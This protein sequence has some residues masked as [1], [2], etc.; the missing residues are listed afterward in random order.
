MRRPLF[1]IW[2]RRHYIPWNKV[3]K[4]VTGMNIVC[5]ALA[6]DAAV[7]IWAVQAPKTILAG[8]CIITNMAVRVFF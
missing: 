2:T 6:S 1:G 4:F 3:Q 8:N 7:P 5:F